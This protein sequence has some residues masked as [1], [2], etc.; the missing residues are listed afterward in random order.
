MLR[1]PVLYGTCFNSLK[2]RVPRRS[3]YWPRLAGFR[4]RRIER[5]IDATILSIFF[6][7]STMNKK[8][9]TF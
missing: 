2:K 6:K 9:I 1:S 7:K 4:Y 3:Q 5:V 8:I